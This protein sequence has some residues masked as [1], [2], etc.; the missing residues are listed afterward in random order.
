M[1]EVESAAFWRGRVMVQDQ[2]EEVTVTRTAICEDQAVL[3]EPPIRIR[4]NRL[5]EPI[6]LQ[7]SPTGISD[8]QVN[9]TVI[10]VHECHSEEKGPSLVVSVLEQVGYRWVPL[11][12][13]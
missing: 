9:K 12:T 6:V 3:S 11:G 2:G 1:A 5:H 13:V 4:L 8:I 7:D 10:G